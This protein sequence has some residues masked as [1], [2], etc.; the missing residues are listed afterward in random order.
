[1]QLDVLRSVIVSAREHGLTLVAA[2]LAFYMFNALVALLVFFVIGVTAVGWVETIVQTG[3]PVLWDDI[4][5]VVSIMEAVIGEGTGRRR[6]ALLAAAILAWS[7]FT[8]FQSVNMAFGHMYGTRSQRSSIR[9]VLNTL[10]ILV[11]VMLAVVLILV[12][13]VGLT[14]ILSPSLATL[15]SVP[16]GGLVLFATFLP[17]FS[18][19]SPPSVS[20]RDVLPGVVLSAVAWTACGVGFRVYLTTSESVEL[21]G[22]AGG[23]MLLLTVLYLA[24]LALLVGVVLNA[25]LADS[26][27]VTD[28]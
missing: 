24:A 7:S 27:E 17:M 2:G 5:A 22:V 19:F 6:A 8:M 20:S 9:V 25:V 1:M 21:Y 13:H 12:L 28:R 18:Q 10:L 23:V 26:V 15:T 16:V 14:T 11:T 3:A 4:E